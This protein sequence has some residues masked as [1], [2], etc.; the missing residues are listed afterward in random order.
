VSKRSLAIGG[1]V[2]AVALVWLIWPSK[3]SRVADLDSAGSNIIAFGDSLTA[4]YGASAGEDYPSRL[5]LLIGSTVINAGVSGDT[6]QDALA[7]LDTDVLARDPRIVIVGLGGNDYLRSIPISATEA[8]LRSIIRKIHD[9]HAMVVLLGFRFPSL[10]VN[11]EDMYDR[12]AS[13]ERCLVVPK[14]L[15]G[16]LTDPSLKSDEV[17]PN[18]RGYQLIAERVAGPLQKLIKRNGGARPPRT[19]LFSRP[20]AARATDRFVRV[21]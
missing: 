21:R 10:N 2:L 15:S 9:A 14:V 13:G 17:H 20:G 4:G 12:V 6:T 18:A 7:R 19:A 11:Y 5:S 8:N 1:A 3:Y 16:I